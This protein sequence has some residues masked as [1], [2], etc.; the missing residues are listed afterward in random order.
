M[1]NLKKIFLL[2][3]CYIAIFFSCTK[4]SSSPVDS[5]IKLSSGL[6]VY[7]PFTGNIADSSGNGNLTTALNGASLTFDAKGNANSAFGGNG[8]GA[9]VVLTNNGSIVFDTAFSMSMNVVVNKIATQM[10]IT[11]VGYADAKGATLGLGTNQ[12]G[13]SN[14]IFGVTDSTAL[15]NGQN[16][17][18]NTAIDTAAFIPQPNVW[19][20]VIN[21]YHK[22][23]LQTYVNGKLN[24]T[25]TGGSTTAHICP[26]AQLI[27]GAG[28]GSNAS[29]NGNL[30]EIRLY[31]RVLNADEIGALSKIF[32]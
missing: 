12:P 8:T 17:S 18:S 16:F 1:N 20:N 5:D 32:Q 26:N 21:I 15:C 22:G 27:I 2:P 14:L 9:S 10:F 31:N 19:C 7:L 13:L 23:V 28:W 6:L 29:I 25:Q 24:S 3:A 11:M 30:D 4:H